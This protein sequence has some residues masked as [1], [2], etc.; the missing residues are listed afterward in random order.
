[1]I[2][3]GDIQIEVGSSV[4]LSNYYTKTDSDGKYALKTDIPS[5]NGYATEQWVTNQ[6]YLTTHQSLENYYTKSEVDNKGYLTEHNPID[7]EFS[8]TSENAVS[9]KLITIRLNEI[10][11]VLEELKKNSGGTTPPTPPSPTTYTLTITSSASD[12]ASITPTYTVKSGETSSSTTATTL[13]FNSG[14]TVEV[15]PS[16]I[17]GY[18]TPN[19]QTVTMDSDK[20]MTF[21]YQKETVVEPTSTVVNL[22]YKTTE[23]NQEVNLMQVYDVSIKRFTVDGVDVTLPTTNGAVLKYTIPSSGEHIA[24]YE[25][26]KGNEQNAFNNGLFNSCQSLVSIDIPS[27]I[28]S[29]G[30]DAFSGC[31]SLSSVTMPNSV[32]SIGNY[33]FYNCSSLSSI[34][35]PNSVK[36]MGGS[37]FWGCSSLKSIDIPNGVTEIC[38][39]TFDSCSS[40]TSVTIPNTVTEI[41][42][43]AFYEC[44]S[45]SS[46]TIPNI[47]TYIGYNAFYS[48]SALTSIDIPSGVTELSTDAFAGCSSLTSVTIPSGVTSLG[49]TVFNSCSN[50]SSVTIEST[51]KLANEGEAFANIASNAVL[52]VPSNLVSE[53]QADYNWVR[54]FKGGIERIGAVGEIE[55]GSGSIGGEDFEAG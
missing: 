10:E 44:R 48:C 55:N 53:Y 18:T 34:T 12:G 45:L 9:N 38:G 8:T 35:I 23:E 5:L 6:G 40:L 37:V 46:V 30:D 2:G 14:T 43:F 54:E 4:D 39:S 26:E 20:Q 13:T 42:N 32:K 33:T 22:K 28:T 7:Q 17:D 1:M 15:T 16:K 36:T 11:R 3:S 52:H 19:A 47:V 41:G 31:T 49:Y 51:T 25:V 27:G 29:I 24:T 21:T 50:L